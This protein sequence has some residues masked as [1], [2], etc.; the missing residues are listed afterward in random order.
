M[1]SRG[2]SERHKLF[3]D[4][5]RTEG[6]GISLPPR[7][8]GVRF[9]RGKRS[10]GREGVFERTYTATVPMTV[11]DKEE[12]NF[13]ADEC[14]E[15]LF[16]AEEQTEAEDPVSNEASECNENPIEKHYHEKNIVS[17]LFSFIGEDD[18]LII[19]LILILAGQHGENNRDII[20][21]LAILLC[22]R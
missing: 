5:K 16:E 18:L 1:Y 12:E 4:G 14:E 7:Y 10:D 8:S 21:L 19:A 17:E 13:E 3:G 20:L 6:E 22:F 11:P 2:Y 9:V 15:A